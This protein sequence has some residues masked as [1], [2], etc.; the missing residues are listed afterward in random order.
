MAKFKFYEDNKKSIDVVIV[1]KD[2]NE[3]LG[4]VW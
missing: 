1:D 4:R 2:G 3:D